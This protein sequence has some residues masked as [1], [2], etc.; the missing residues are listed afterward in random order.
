[1]GGVAGTEEPHD[2]GEEPVVVGVPADSCAGA[3]GVDEHVVIGVAGSDGLERAG[4][5][6]RAIL[7]G[8]DHGV[9]GGQLVGARG[10]VVDDVPA[11]GL[12]G[13]PFAHVA[14]GCTGPLCQRGRG[15]RPGV[16]HRLV[17]AQPV[18]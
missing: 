16:G 11:G 2:P 9:L 7:V 17:Q 18:A 13:E 15:D 5:E 12:I 10:R 8:N 3:E 1:V 14:L 6:D 4:E